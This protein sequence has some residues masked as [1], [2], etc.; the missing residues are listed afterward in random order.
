M[1][2]TT[3]P[4]LGFGASG[5]IGKTQVY[6]K[7][8]GVAYA[9][10]YVVPSNPNSLSQQA[11][12]G[13][14]KWLAA[15]FKLLDPAVQAV[16]FLGAKG[17]PLTDR[18][19]YTSANLSALRGT[20]MSPATDLSGGVMSPG[21]NGGLVA[22]AVAVTDAT[23]HIASVAMTAPA[24]PAGWTIT[25][26]QAVA[27][28][29]QDANT[30]VFYTSYFAADTSSPYSPQISTGAAGT[31]AVFAWFKFAKPDGSVAYGPSVYHAVTLA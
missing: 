10:R 26:A 2:K 14:F 5:A 16:F 17:R 8:R 23:G 18:N 3:A 13:V 11:T 22:A 31:Y 21:V 7:W 1:A 25:A 27:F 9:R 29:Q 20:D 4:L 15:T 12:R 24:L 28:K 19:L 30:D 6:A